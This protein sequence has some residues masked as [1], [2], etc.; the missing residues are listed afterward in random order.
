MAAIKFYSRPINTIHTSIMS[1]LPR[2]KFSELVQS[3]FEVVRSCFSRDDNKLLTAANRVSAK[4]KDAE[5][6]LMLQRTRGINQRHRHEMYHHRVKGFS[7]NEQ[8]FPG[9]TFL[10]F[11]RLNTKCNIQKT[12]LHCILMIKC[13][14]YVHFSVC[15][16][17]GLVIAILLPSII[18]SKQFLRARHSPSLAQKRGLD[19]H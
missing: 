7:P 11:C 12:Y 2:R 10:F 18:Q 5:I 4:E 9:L 1:V 16:A 13:L 8:I 14:Y 6:V 19:D 17:F 15:R 3:K